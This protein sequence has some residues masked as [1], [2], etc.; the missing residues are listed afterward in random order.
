MARL[1]YTFHTPLPQML[2]MYWDDA[3][4]WWPQVRSIHDELRGR[5]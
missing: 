3:L 1:S 5:A 4:L 2:T